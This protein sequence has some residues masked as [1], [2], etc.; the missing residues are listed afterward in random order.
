VISRNSS[1]RRP[2][3]PSGPVGRGLLVEILVQPYYCMHQRGTSVE[4]GQR[5]TSVK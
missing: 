2:K 5:G 4:E 1:K 3:G